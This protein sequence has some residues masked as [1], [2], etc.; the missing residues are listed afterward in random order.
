MREVMRVP[1]SRRPLVVA[2]ALA[3][4]V[5]TFAP[6]TVAPAADDGCSTPPAVFPIEDLRPGMR[7][8]G[9]TVIQGREPVT[10]R[11]KILG[12]QPGGIAPGLDLIL[13]KASGTAI[14]TAGGIAAG[15]SGSPVKIDGR[16]VGAVAYGFWSGDQT[17]G[18]LTPAAAMMEV[19]GYPTASATASRAAAR[20]RLSKDVRR[21][22][23]RIAGTTLA[24]MPASLERLPV[25]L[26]VSGLNDR[27]FAALE[28]R[29]REERLPFLPFRGSSAAAP[30]EE[31]LATEPLEPGDAI[32]AVYSYGDVTYAGIGTVTATC[33]DRLVAFGHPMSFTGSRIPLGMNG[34]DVITTVADPIWGSFKLANVAEP[35][36]TID[37]DRQAGVRGIEGALPSL[38]TVRSETYNPDLGRSRVGTTSI[39][40]RDYWLADI[41][42]SHV[43]MNI[44]LV[45]DQVGPGMLTMDWQ[46][47]GL[48]ATGEP[49]VLARDNMY[50]SD[51]DVSWDSTEEFH[52]HLFA[53]TEKEFEKVSLTGIDVRQTATEHRRMARIVELRSA[54][55]LQPELEV[56]DALR[57]HPGETIRLQVLLEPLDGGEAYTTDLEVRVPK[58]A[59]R[60]G[61]LSLRGGNTDEWGVR[62]NSFDQMLARL[63]NRER[64]SDL[65]VQLWARGMLHR[66]K[67]TFDQDTLFAPEEEEGHYLR[68]RVIR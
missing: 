28:D 21:I 14:R 56:R 58:R 9:K 22:A 40:R 33:G 38:L 29:I 63:A 48:R 36:G 41:A 20:V 44:D 19:L 47:R 7:G 16:L 3:L 17:I 60:S 26:G 68:L 32:A 57:V 52:Y 49:F 24:E 64:N 39:A 23:A 46:I 27:G 45:Y 54:S 4:L 62:A 37:Q 13:V 1:R 6:A 66:K 34:A 55:E 42:W 12:I 25:P 61:D 53:L 8:T 31:A 50:W 11:V 10:F 30:T 65:V 51:W 59:R 15:F 67:L 18:G 5:L 43:W 2:S 35:H